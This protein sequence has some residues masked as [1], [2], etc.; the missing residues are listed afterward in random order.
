MKQLQKGF[1]LIELMIVVAIIGILAAVAIPAYQD[2]I[3]RAQAA[4]GVELLAGGKTPMQ[5]YFS[6]KGVWPAYATT[7]MGNVAGKYTSQVKIQTGAGLATGTLEML[8]TM[9]STGV[10]T[11]IKSK[12]IS[13]ITGDG[14]KTWSCINTASADIAAK[15]LPASCR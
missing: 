13:M 4:E 15:Y 12:K 9:K 8:A 10:S 1:T 11:G 3:A 5:E 14:G 7:V 6:D 2:Y